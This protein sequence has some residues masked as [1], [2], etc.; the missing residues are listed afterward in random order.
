MKWYWILC[1]VVICLGV[2]LGTIIFI[3][4]SV[5]KVKWDTIT[6]DFWKSQEQLKNFATHSAMNRVGFQVLYINLAR[7][8]TKRFFME[9]QFN[10]YKIQF[11]RIEAIDG[12]SIFSD[13]GY[14]MGIEYKNNYRLSKK[15]LAC[16]LSHLKAIKH[17][18]D[19]GMDK[20]VVM[21]DNISLTLIPFWK[22][23]LPELLSILEDWNIVQLHNGSNNYKNNL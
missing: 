16:T 6:D 20:V 4:R 22:K 19:K 9:R 5:N 11:E 10:R 17:A 2:I 12:T 18:Y 3:H 15:E 1:L 7:D 21:E 8:A 14:I 13:H 23:T